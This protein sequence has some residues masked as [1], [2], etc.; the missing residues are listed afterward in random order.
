MKQLNNALIFGINYG[1]SVWRGKE[2][3]LYAEYPLSVKCKIF[4]KLYDSNT[5]HCID[6]EFTNG[7]CVSFW[8]GDNIDKATV[9]VKGEEFNITISGKGWMEPYNKVITLVKQNAD[10]REKDEERKRKYDEAMAN[11]KKRDEAKGGQPEKTWRDLASAE[12]ANNLVDDLEKDN[13]RKGTVIYN[14]DMH[15]ELISNYFGK[16]NEKKIYLVGNI[17]LKKQANFLDNFRSKQIVDLFT[18]GCNVLL[19]YDITFWG[20]GDTG[21]AIISSG[22]DL[23]LL[24]KHDSVPGEVYVLNNKKNGINILLDIKE[25]KRDWYLF[26]YKDKSSMFVLETRKA[27]HET[28]RYFINSLRKLVKELN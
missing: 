11:Q 28:K 5:R 10:E 25:T 15:H 20:K 22:E 18:Q 16:L 19:Y 14:G 23:Y 13:K 12:E 6:F 21:Y 2:G 26:E 4:D 17:D 27:F 1:G 24:V 3:S 9:S 7:E 8:H